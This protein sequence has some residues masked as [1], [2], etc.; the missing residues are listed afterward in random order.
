LNIIIAKRVD[1]WLE[2][3]TLACGN[4]VFENQE[5]E[6]CNEE[7]H[8]VEGNYLILGEDTEKESKE[9][10]YCFT[11]ETTKELAVS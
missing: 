6:R 8:E 1:S 5:E 10:R 2:H 9:R 11:L 3:W 7:E 4:T